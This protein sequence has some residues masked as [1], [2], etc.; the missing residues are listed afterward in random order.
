[1]SGAGSAAG[2]AGPGAPPVALAAEPVAPVLAA[3]TACGVG[4]HGL[5]L[6]RRFRWAR[7]IHRQRHDGV[8]RLG[9]VRPVRPCDLRQR[10]F[11]PFDRRLRRAVASSPRLPPNRSADQSLPAGRRH[12]LDR[13]RLYCN[14]RRRRLNRR[15]ARH[16]RRYCVGEHRFDQR[17]AA[18][19]R[20]AQRPA[21]G[22]VAS[23]TSGYAGLSDAIPITS[24][25][26]IGRICV[27]AAARRIVGEIHC[28]DPA[29]SLPPPAS[30]APPMAS[31]CSTARWS[32]AS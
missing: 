20:D 32:A 27:C 23:T 28:A 9:C 17:I 24:T 5:K 18:I 31:D 22:S 16:V 1:M 10:R 30:A 7:R 8:L 14:C 19:G 21:A 29:A 26:L 4:G 15:R 2:A 11:A 13:L 25:R 12:F 6:L 3:A